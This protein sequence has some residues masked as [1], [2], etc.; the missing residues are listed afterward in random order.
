MVGRSTSLR[1]NVLCRVVEANDELAD[2]LA[3]LTHHRIRTFDPFPGFPFSHLELESS[4]HIRVHIPLL[5]LSYIQT[6]RDI[7]VIET[8]GATWFSAVFQY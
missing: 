7:Q 6:Y 8:I 1:M 4:L 3:A 5:K 2:A